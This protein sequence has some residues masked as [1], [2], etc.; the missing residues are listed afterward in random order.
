M[1]ATPYPGFRRNEPTTIGRSIVTAANEGAIRDAI[2]VYSTSEVDGM[3]PDLS[4]YATQSA[5]DAIETQVSTNTLNIDAL[6]A[7]KANT[8]HTHDASAIVSGTIADAR[9]SANVARLNANL[10]FTISPVITA[11]ST[12]IFDPAVYFGSTTIANARSAAMNGFVVGSGHSF[13]YSS[14]TGAGGTPDAETY[15]Y[16]AGSVEQRSGIIAQ[17]FRVS[18]T[19]ST[20]T[21]FEGI[22]IDASAVEGYRIYVD[23]GSAG[24]FERSLSFGANQQ[25]WGYTPW[26]TLAH[27]TGAA[28][29]SG[30]TRSGSYTFATRPSAS[31]FPGSTIIVSDR[32]NRTEKSNGTN[33][34]LASDESVIAT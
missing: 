31:A 29:F 10:A 27:T 2:G 32:S 16:A 21:N 18:R 14:T 28:T 11:A 24:G 17:R 23:R 12:I 7:N 30:P 19:W 5:V 22:A 1:A 6:Q 33:W 3:I 9:L 25:G 4:N 8:S 13:R 20:A 26:L 34:V 15:R